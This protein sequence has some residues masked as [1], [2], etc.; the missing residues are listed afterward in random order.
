MLLTSL[1]RPHYIHLTIKK[2]KRKNKQSKTNDNMF[3]QIYFSIKFFYK[4]ENDTCFLTL[5]RNM[6]LLLAFVYH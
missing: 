6:Q 5:F 3:E 4:V 1:D 2:K